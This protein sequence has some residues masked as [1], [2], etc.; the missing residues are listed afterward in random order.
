MREGKNT[1]PEHSENVEHNSTGQHLLINNRNTS[2]H[3]I[4]LVSSFLS[5]CKYVCTYVHMYVYIFKFSFIFQE[6]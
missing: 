4:F 2:N 6:M 5:H 3:L 1:I